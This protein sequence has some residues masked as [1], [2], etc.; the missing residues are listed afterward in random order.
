MQIIQ[1]TI[2]GR[3]TSGNPPN[4]FEQI[5]FEFDGDYLDDEEQ[6]SPQTVYFKDTSRTIITKNDSP[7]VGFTHSVNPY[8]GCSHGWIWSSIIPP[9]SLQRTEVG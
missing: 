9:C 1:P 6:P 8:R 5:A 2:K 4:R 3:G 7:D